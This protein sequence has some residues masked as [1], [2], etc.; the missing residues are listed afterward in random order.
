M[1]FKNA[2]MRLSDTSKDC[3]THVTVKACGFLVKDFFLI[4][5]FLYKN[6]TRPPPPHCR[7]ALPR[8][9]NLNKLVSALPEDASKQV[10]IFLNWLCICN[11]W[12]HATENV[13]KKWTVLLISRVLRLINQSVICELDWIKGVGFVYI[14]GSCQFQRDVIGKV[15]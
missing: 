6:S 13:F 3:G 11:K 9:S 7:L 12:P 15:T 10:Y 8:G 5:I 14:W 4:Y 1:K 2:N